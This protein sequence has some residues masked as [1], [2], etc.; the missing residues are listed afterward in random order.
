MLIDSCIGDLQGHLPK[1]RPGISG[2]SSGFLDRATA[3]RRRSCRSRSGV[4]HPSACRSRRLEYAPRQWPLEAD[5][6]QRAISVRSPRARRLDDATRYRLG[7]AHPCP[8]PWKQSV[9]PIVEAGLADLVDDGHETGAGSPACCRCRAIPRARWVS[10]STMAGE[11]AIFCGDALH[12]RS[13][14][15]S[16]TCRRRPVRQKLASRNTKE[17]LRRGRR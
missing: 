13:R 7:P 14:S 3:N 15:F 4:L 2:A 11:R 12:T 8:S 16:P 5:L 6:S 17:D 9:I 10:S 1:S